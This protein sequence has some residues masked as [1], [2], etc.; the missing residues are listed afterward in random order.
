MVSLFSRGTAQL[1][2]LLVTPG[3][4]WISGSQSDLEGTSTFPCRGVRGRAG[5]SHCSVGGLGE[6]WGGSRGRN[7]YDWRLKSKLC[8]QKK[9]VR[10]ISTNFALSNC[11]LA[12]N[13]VH[14]GDW[15]LLTVT[16]RGAESSVLLVII[17][18]TNLQQQ[19]M[20]GQ[21]WGHIAFAHICQIQ[22]FIH[23]TVSQ[24]V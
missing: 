12:F 10:D 20:F 16:H 19:L 6:D 7:S 8:K 13:K 23:C 21:T 11:L 2:D 17:Q 1:R 5:A 15:A 4:E 14:F 18:E 9:K 22:L 3:S 24:H